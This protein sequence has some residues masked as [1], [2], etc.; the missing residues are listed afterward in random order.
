MITTGAAVLP[1]DAAEFFVEPRQPT[2][3]GSPIHRKV[4]DLQRFAVQIRDRGNVFPRPG[5]RRERPVIAGCRNGNEGRLNGGVEQINDQGD[6]QCACQGKHQ[7]DP[8][9]PPA[10]AAD[11][12]IRGQRTSQLPTMLWRGLG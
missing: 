1:D 12:W 7:T 4:G 9:A 11:K 3:R 10:T 8:N 6:Q 2:F 5:I